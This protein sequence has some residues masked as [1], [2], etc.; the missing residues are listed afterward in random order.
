MNAF[1]RKHVKVSAQLLQ[2]RR[3]QRFITYKPPRRNTPEMVIFLRVDSC[4][5]ST[6]RIGS[7]RINTYD[8]MLS[9]PEDIKKS[10]DLWRQLGP[11]GKIHNLVK[12]VRSLPKRS[13][14]L[15]DLVNY[16]G[17]IPIDPVPELKVIDNNN[18]RWNSTYLMLRRALVLRF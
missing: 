14:K 16:K 9:E 18:I 7:A 17:S 1:Q 5:L 13:E 2:W 11:I 3:G 6:A 10:L 12:F 8:E 15:S 4:S